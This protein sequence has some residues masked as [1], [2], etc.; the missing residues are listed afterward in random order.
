M[1]NGS[2]MDPRAPMPEG[3]SVAVQSI[4]IVR[5]EDR[6]V[7]AELK[8]LAARAVR[9]RKPL[10]PR[11]ER[12]PVA[13][14]VDPAQVRNLAEPLAPAAPLPGAPGA[15]LPPSPPPAVTFAGGS[16]DDT[17]IPP[18]TMGVVS[19]RFVF[20]PLNNNVQIFDLSG[21]LFSEMPLDTFWD[22][23]PQPMNAFDPRAAYDPFERRFLFVSTAN[24]ALPTSSLLFA[25]TETDDPQ[26]NWITGFIRVDPSEQG[27]VWLD[28]PSIGFTADKVTVQVNMYTLGTND[29]AGSSIYVWDKLRLYNPPH[30]PAAH[31]FVLLDQG[32]PQVPAVTYDFGQSTQYLVS[33]WTG[34]FQGDGYYNIHE[35]T[36]SVSAGTV[37]LHRIGYI[38][39]PGTTWNSEVSGNFAPQLGTTDCIDAGDDRILSVV[40]RRGSL[41]FCHTAFLPASGPTRTA[42]QWLQVEIDSWRIRQLGRV[43][44]PDGGVFYAYPTMAVNAEGD[45]LLGFSSFSED[46]FASGA[47]AYRSAG[48]PPGRMRSPHVYAPGLSTYHKTFGEESNRWGDYSNTQVDPADDRSFWTIQE[49]ASEQ[50]DFWATKW[51]R[52]T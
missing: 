17:A 37:A 7:P 41:W 52:V 18:D 30:T 38:R 3:R 35:I 44:D 19:D 20:N 8:V 31:L 4:R 25:V 11:K 2:R 29:F 28:F 27:S 40:C 21:T 45:A 33:T 16:D 34:D 13:E 26:G 5:F 36:G 6:A 51:A 12:L 32:G 22:V 1:A 9:A 14:D 15:P 49:H 39:T 42:V 10:R 46:Q 48:D 47:Y 23:F 43:D 50:Q 24:A